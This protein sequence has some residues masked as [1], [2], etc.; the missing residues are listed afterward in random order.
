MFFFICLFIL[1]LSLF[2][3]S[4]CVKMDDFNREEE[5]YGWPISRY[6]ECKEVQDQLAPFLRLYQTASEFHSQHQQWVHGPLS[7]VNPDKVLHGSA[8][9]LFIVF[10]NSSSQLVSP[11]DPH[12]S[13]RVRVRVSH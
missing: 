8:T 5:S 13:L 6:P 1:F 3:F 10:Y 7:G 2:S 4:I 11:Q 9:A 12:V